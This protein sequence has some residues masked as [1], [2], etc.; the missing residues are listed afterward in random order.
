MTQACG[1]TSLSLS[2]D[3]FLRRFSLLVGRVHN[4]KEAQMLIVHRTY[5]TGPLELVT[6]LYNNPCLHS[7]RLVI[8]CTFVNWKN[9]G[10]FLFPNSGWGVALVYSA[11]AHQV[12]IGGGSVRLSVANHGQSHKFETST[13]AMQEL[14]VTTDSHVT[15]RVI[16]GGA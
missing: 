3:N 10:L 7:Y 8:A 12:T 6:S 1:I 11:A 2:L 4:V 5:V 14:H 15:F 9:R 13:F 16:S